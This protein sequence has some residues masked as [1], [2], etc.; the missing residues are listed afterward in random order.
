M[1][2][3]KRGL[4]DL[5]IN[6]TSRMNRELENKDIKDKFASLEGFF[7]LEVV[8]KKN[9]RRGV[10]VRTNCVESHVVLDTLKTE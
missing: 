8:V 9:W 5:P 2:L 7:N 1:T 10:T 6:A 4:Q 3:D